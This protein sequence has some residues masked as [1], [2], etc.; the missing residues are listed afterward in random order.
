[1]LCLIGRRRSR[2]DPRKP[3]S[4]ETRTLQPMPSMLERVTPA[5]A[6]ETGSA[7]P[8]VNAGLLSGRAIEGLGIDI[9]S[10]RPAT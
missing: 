1:M 3:D 6:V 7:P 9:A 10:G 4:L 5:Q 8:L 2:G